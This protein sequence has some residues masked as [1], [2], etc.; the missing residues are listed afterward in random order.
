[1]E[2]RH[3]ISAIAPGASFPS[4]QPIGSAQQDLLGRSRFAEALA[5]NIRDWKHKDSLVIG[6]HGAW[7]S[8]K[9][10]VKNMVL[11]SLRESQNPNTP[12]ILEFSPW[13]VSGT[14]TIAGTL[15]D[16]LGIALGLG[17]PGKADTKLAKLFFSYA[18]SLKCFS[19][20]G[21]LAGAL[22]PILSPDHAAIGGAVAASAI[23]AEQSGQA[24]ETGADALTASADAA[25][26]SLTEL[27]KDLGEHLS[28]LKRP[29]LVVIDDIDRLTTEE[30]LQV[31]QLV[32]VNADFPNVIYLLLY[33]RSIV[34]KA[35]DHVSGARGHEFLQKIVQVDFHIPHA[36]RNAV[37]KVLFAGMD[38]LLQNE[39][40]LS[41]FDQQ[42]WR[43]LFV[44]GIGAYF[45]NL[46][47]V[48]RF[49]GALS[50][51]LSQF[52]TGGSLE[53]NPIDLIGL[54]SLRVFEPA[55]FERLPSA[56]RLLTRD[57]GQVLFD[58]IK[59][60]EVEGAITQLLA[61]VPE[62][63]QPVARAVLS[64]LF[65][66]V[67]PSF[68]TE[69]GVSSHKQA[70]LRD[71]RVCHFDLFDRFFALSV[72][73]GD[74]SQSELDQLIRLAPDRDAFLRECLVLLDRGVLHVALARLDA[75]KERIPLTAMAGYV[76]AFCDLVELCPERESALS[77]DDPAGQAWRLVYFG[78]IREPD[79]GKRLAILKEAFENSSGLRLPVRIVS[80]DQ[81]DSEAGDEGWKHLV[82]EAG[83]KELQGVCV[84][85]IRRTSTESE[86]VN[87]AHLSTFLFAWGKWG[88]QDEVRQ[89]V[90]ERVRD[91]AGALWLLRTV[92][93]KA[94]VGGMQG[95]RIV[96]RIE[97]RVVE[98]FSEVDL[99]QRLT[100]STRTDDLEGLDKTG[101]EEFRKALKRQAEGRP[102]DDWH[103]ESIR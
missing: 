25:A 78:L 32:K 47:H 96:Y 4:D 3:T 86:F 49:L 35:L 22:F 62:E 44:D 48:Y 81:P 69:H 38:A 72:A 58:R 42:R 64:S 89:W 82:D 41:L 97:L 26:K 60:E 59:Q 10:S 37:E 76:S 94:S 28:T 45:A 29:I 39:T 13:Q 103:W 11:E 88:S 95:T 40:I 34:E 53:V 27:K 12:Q 68:D 75:Y 101:L 100:K 90:S 9:T 2:E 19:Y 24:L 50:F 36:H 54:E 56:K 77:L 23:A 6:L 43:T 30:I 17:K 55:L 85:K 7:G 67:S 52:Q 66:P 91:T 80:W 57:E 31:I 61:S 21:K 5:T 8:G 1:M 63:R 71:L 93:G 70:W 16:E 74:V 20:V 79:L 92:L 84:D 73:E 18:K 87:N 33:E 14:G 102:D 83:L 65:P 98:Q 99:I 15:L 51:H 46:R